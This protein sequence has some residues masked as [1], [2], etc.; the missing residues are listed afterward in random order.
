MRLSAIIALGA[1]ILPAAAEDPPPAGAA[2]V[3]VPAP[4]RAPAEDPFADRLQ[5]FATLRE[6]HPEQATPIAAAWDAAL[7]RA[8]AAAAALEQARADGGDDAV[9]DPLDEDAERA[10]ARLDALGDLVD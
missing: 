5:R 2:A 3:L 8:R 1:L 6:E 10:A 4:L 7:R 9:I